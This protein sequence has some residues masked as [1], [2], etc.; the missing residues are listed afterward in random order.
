MNR[1]TRLFVAVCLPLLAVS[2]WAFAQGSSAS[3]S[4]VIKDTAGAPIPGAAVIVRNPGTSQTREA[5][6]DEQGRYAFLS[7][8]LGQH[9][10]TAQKHGFKPARVAVELSIGQQAEADITL[11]P[12]EVTEGVEVKGGE[13]QLAVETRS[14]IF[15]QLVT[16]GQIENLPLNGR[17]FSQLILLQPGTTQARSDQGDILSGKG[18]KVS[19]HGARTSQNAY[20]LDGTD[21]LDALG[22]N[23]ASAQGLV[24]GIESVQEFAVLTNTY[25]A[26]YGRAAGGVFNIATR[27]G[28]NQFHGTVF[29][30]LRNSALDARNFFDTEK[31]PFKRN[32][33]GASGGGPIIKNKAFIFGA[34]EGFRERLGL[35]I[36]EPVPSLAARGGAFLPQGR[37]VS[38]AVVPYLQLIPAP[39][40]DN[41]NGEKATYIG[42]FNQPSNL[43]T[44]NVRV[45]HNFS[46]NDSLFARYTHND[47]EITFLNPETFPGFPNRGSN[48]QKFFTI[49]ETHV[50]S[51][52]LVNNIRYAFNR[53]SPDESPAPPNGFK[54]LAFIPGDL[55]GTI[56]ISGFKRFGTDR[57]TPRSFLQ[58]TN[59]LSDDLSFV[60]GA[61]LMKAGM[62]I[63]YFRI[64]G[65]SASRNRGEFTINTFSDFLQG[66]SRDFVGLAPGQDDT[67]R[68]HRQWLFGFFFQDD[69][70]ALPNLTLNLGL[71]YE[72]ITVP[73]ETDGKMTNV[74]KPT[75]RE[76][77]VGDPLFENPSL[78]NFSPRVGFAYSP[79]FK[80]GLLGKLTGGA[81]K[82]A[83]RGGFG[84]FFDQLLYSVYG[85][86]TFK[87]P[88]YFKQVRIANAPFP[89]V[90]PL[91]A[92]GQGLVDTFAIDFNPSPSYAMQYNLNIQRELSS[93]L[94]VTAAYVGSRG[95]HLWR[96]A[97]FNNAIPLTPDGARFP[98]V[99]NPQRRNPNF[100]NIRYKVSDAQSFYNAFQLSVISRLNRGFQAQLSYTLAKSVDDQSSSLGR[101]EFA[102][103]QART[104][105]PYNKKLNRGLSDFD[106]RN[107]LSFSF[108]YELPFGPGQAWGGN[109][110]GLAR[111][112]IEGWQFNGI[113]QASSGIP[114]SPIFTFDQDRDATTDNEQRPNLKPGI[115]K[116][117]KVSRLQLFD[118]TVFELPAVGSRG[119]LGR[120]VIIGPGLATFDPSLVKFF[121]LN[122]ERTRSAQ[123]RVEFFN[124]FNHANFAIP[125]IGNLTVFN[126]ATE[127]NTTAGQITQTSTPGRQLQFALRIAF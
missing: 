70:K 121:Y 26:E 3:L 96:E 25:S 65:N 45:D 16:R 58:N 67:I 64:S 98:P 5:V 91:L 120:N 124:V 102:N 72:F 111:V 63:E 113:F 75:D 20:L 50:F 82:T 32:Q 99:A 29:E 110:K 77:S 59:Q 112:L 44:Y 52:A 1:Q 47:S 117:P 14:S 37:T 35:T 60:K 28:T 62:N 39:T 10:V 84:V 34:Y 86:M 116:I 9:E 61:H 57:N 78:K 22:R 12:G 92:G 42:Q 23:A 106:V 11:A 125:T 27:S 118:P 51:G 79:D 85:N 66:R 36:V 122:S 38:P 40:I 69:W 76:V 49:S 71:R 126:S 41:P 95:I 31:P 127:R 93:R 18:A 43:D 21:I 55:V 15:G 115:T 19:V 68:H 119:A 80:G 56:F 83:I 81:G 87:H 104:V 2:H 105:D 74:R 100:A 123:F 13:Q 33:F 101:N 7:L 90:Y 53:T 54:D 24:S 48:N 88:P 108:S 103:G 6:S 8:D 109:A 114:V 89:N 94:V 46:R 97:D 107:N 30:F 17:D 73:T 4:G